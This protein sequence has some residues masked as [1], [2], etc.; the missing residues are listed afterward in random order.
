[1]KP[2]I[3]IL[4]LVAFLC[5]SCGQSENIYKVEDVGGVPRL[6]INGKPSRARMLYVSPTYFMLGTP[7]SRVSY[8]GWTSTF[9]EI[10][11]L[12]KA[13]NGTIDIKP[14]SKITDC[15]IACADISEV[16]TGKKIWS[17]D[18]EKIDP[19]AT[20]TNNATVSKGERGGKKVLIFN[21]DKSG[22]TVIRLKDVNLEAGKKYRLDLTICG[23]TKFN[24]DA[25]FALNG[26]LIEPKIRSK[27]G[28]QTKIAK[29]VGNVDIITFP[30]QA[31]DFMN[32]DGSCNYDNLKG[33][34]EEIISA[35]PEAKILVRIRFY[36]PAW[37]QKKYPDDVVM[38]ENGVRFHFPCV[39]SQRFRDDSVKVLETVIDF[40]EKNYGKNIIGYHPGGGSS[41]E[42]F[43]P[44]AHSKLHYGFN[45][46]AV[47]A[48]KKWVSKKYK[49][50]KELQTA[51][52][53]GKITLQNVDVPSADER[54]QV[55]YFADLK[56]QQKLV[57]Y[58]IFLQDEM[59]DMVET[60]GK[61][62]R[63]KAPNKLSILF[64][65]YTCEFG[66]V[67]KGLAATAH[68]ALWKVA[69]SPYF[70]MLSG[71]ISYLK[72]NLGDAGSTMGASETLTRC[73]K[74]WID[75]DDI[76]THRT[77]PTQQS[78]TP[79]AYLL[80]TCEDTMKVLQ[81]DLA[82]QAIRNHTCWWMDLAGIGWF[83]DPKMW[84]LIP[85][86]EKIENDMIKNPVVYDP[87]VAVII[88]ERSTYYLGAKG[89]ALPS[90]KILRNDRSKISTCAVTFGHVLFE[91]FIYG[92][93]MNPKLAIVQLA[94]ALNAKERALLREKTK[95]IGA[96][97][98]GLT[99]YIDTDKNKFSSKAT[100]EATGFKLKRVKDDISAKV[101]PTQEGKKIGLND[102]FGFDEKVKPL[103]SPELKDGDIV[104]AVYQNDM[105]AIVQRGKH[106]FCGI[107]QVPEALYRYAAKIAEAQI[108]SKQNISTWASGAY[109]SITC[110]DGIDEV[111]DVELDIPSD[112]EIFDAITGEK[113]GKAPKLT[114]KM[115]RGDNRVLRLG[116]GNVEFTK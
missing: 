79:S 22:N 66:D 37:W 104:L 75:E 40:C 41:C 43:Y 116:K 10:P 14:K 58:N 3:S 105:P 98:I 90:S 6:T 11:P 60:L 97:F 62:I 110:T 24:Y 56:T 42:W 69:N 108:Y 63:K 61:V 99:A 49:S 52:N 109:L 47:D 84:T 7:T 102:I 107:A 101:G 70:D 36:P 18:V 80:R 93:K 25:Y 92:K 94:C 13:I 100:E 4:G 106:I 76:R 81:R 53:D 83:D 9:V 39:S 71:P 64:Y 67:Y 91:D 32:E 28:E 35:N 31:A 114:L 77:P 48:W 38:N 15:A 72:R 1:M 73:G 103:L 26:T 17:L 5:A 59:V 68:F 34:L 20:A 96:L 95:D 29:E 44:N 19:R 87:D 51:W 86:F 12:E 65:G 8:A 30:V 27:V 45:K 113:L 78:I 115:K 21:P 16:A 89:T 57:D 50:D 2:Y 88:D 85:A 112:K 33:A 55:K 74:I 46:S 111:H 54:N 82:R 23:T